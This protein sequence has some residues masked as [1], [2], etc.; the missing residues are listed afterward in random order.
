MYYQESD[1]I[2]ASSTFIE[3]DVVALDGYL[4]QNQGNAV[5]VGSA[6]DFTELDAGL[7][8]N[9]LA[10]YVAADVV[11][12]TSLPVC[13]RDDVLL[14]ERDD[15][16]NYVCDLCDRTI[17]E[18]DLMFEDAYFPRQ[19][20]F[21]CGD[22]IAKAAEGGEVD[23][24]QKIRGCSNSDRVADV[25]FVH[26]LDGDAH[27]T[28]HPKDKPDD[29]FPKWLGEEFPNVGVWSLGYNAAKFKWKGTAM[30]LVDRATNTLA[31]LEASGI[32][33]R[34]LIFMVHSLGGLVVKQCLR[35]ANDFGN[36]DWE[37]ISANT[38]GVL[39]LATPHAG[40]D[41]STYLSYLGTL[42][43]TNVTVD[44][45]KAHSP[46]LRDLNLWF[47]QHCN[48]SEM[49]IDV[50]FETLTT[51]GVKVVDET[52]ADPGVS[53]VVPMAIDANHIEICKPTSKTH[54]VFSRA[55]LLLQKILG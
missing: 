42:L 29:F 27:S 31:V 36:S 21:E 54:L 13:T 47:R 1:I 11:A 39:F 30:P 52:S 10:K 16:G 7:V 41:M 38:K 40:S 9:I 34:P 12:Q 20:K 19:T 45:L 37:Q 14:E 48:Q 25:V 28:W 43:R 5:R 18:E 49:R 55:R 2:V 50:L 3:E 4:F 24:I 26:G 22:K 51:K 33:T 32:G 17:A 44:E 8:E 23:G 6:A 15:S 53:G 46:A 35:H